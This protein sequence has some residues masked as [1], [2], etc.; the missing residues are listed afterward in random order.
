MVDKLQLPSAGTPGTRQ[1]LAL[2]DVDLVQSSSQ[3]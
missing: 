2:G 1:V 3:T